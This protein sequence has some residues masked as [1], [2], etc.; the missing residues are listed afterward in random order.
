MGFY[1]F[2]AIGFVL[3]IVAMAMFDEQSKKLR[4][5]LIYDHGS[6]FVACAGFCVFPILNFFVGLILLLIVLDDKEK[7]KNNIY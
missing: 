1:I 7:I 4:S 5:H 3:S 6:T 2:I